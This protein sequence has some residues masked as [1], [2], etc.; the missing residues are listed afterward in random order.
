MHFIHHNTAAVRR[1]RQFGAVKPSIE[2]GRTR[3]FYLRALGD[4]RGDLA[5]FA[6]AQQP[7]FHFIADVQHADGISQLAG[8]LHGDA[9]E[10]CNDVAGFDAGAI[11]GRS[12][13]DAGHQG[14]G[15]LGETEF[16]G[17][18]RVDAIKLNA[19]DAAFHL[20]V[21]NELV[22]DA[23]DHIDRDR[24]ADTDVAAGARQDCRI[25]ADQFAAQIH[26]GA[27]GVS[28]VDRGVGLDEILVAAGFRV[29]VAAPQRAHDARGDGVLQSERVADRD[30]VVADLELA[31]IAERHGDQ[32]RLLSLQYC[33]IGA[34]VAADDFGAESAVIEQGDGDLAG[35]LDHVVIGDDVAVFRV[36]DDA[37]SC[38]LE[39]A[40]TR[41]RILRSV[42]KS[43]EKGI[44]QERI[45][46][47]LLFDG[48]TRGDVHD[49][50]RDALDHGGERR[51]GSG[52]GG[53]NRGERPPAACSRADCSR[54]KRG[55]CK[56]ETQ[57][58]A[59]SFGI[60]RPAREAGP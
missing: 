4:Q 30:H 24:K 52:I 60:L 3:G 59:R 41:L 44:V 37:R 32:I 48:P 33:D 11:R 29:D 18:V 9:I 36:D 2:I 23:A 57:I 22:H 45:A 14:A 26:Q 56:L 10:R 17:D 15:R 8:T 20:T 54:G 53:G 13:H 40:L 43:A 55:C 27:A 31:R 25:D 21:F 47:G 34:F 46:A 51:H 28:G 50:R 19:E 38:A 5:R 42:E 35:V 6:V 58:H 1:I 49:G 12:L 7:Q 16:L 39:L